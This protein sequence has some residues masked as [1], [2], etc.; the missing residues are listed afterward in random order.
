M[1]STPVVTPL[2][3]SRTTSHNF[4][5]SWLC[6]VALTFAAAFLSRPAFAQ[7]PAPTNF[8]AK[9]GPDCDITLTWNSV[10]GAAGYLIIR[11][12]PGGWVDLWAGGTS[13]LDPSGTQAMEL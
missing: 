13:Y 3:S 12:S 4:V 8:A 5:V 1:D 9:V 6:F 7:L 10:P 11:N 2:N